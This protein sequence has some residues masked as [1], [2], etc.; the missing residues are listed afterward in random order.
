MGAVVFFFFG[1]GALKHIRCCTHHALKLFV[2]FFLPSIVLLNWSLQFAVLNLLKLY[3][4][5]MSLL[6]DLFF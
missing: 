6:F 1:G 5:I 3:I 4:E 2:C